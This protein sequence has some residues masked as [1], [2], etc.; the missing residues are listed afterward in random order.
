MRYSI[1]VIA[2]ALVFTAPVHSQPAPSDEGGVLLAKQIL[3]ARQNARLRVSSTSFNGGGIIPER[4]A[5]NGENASPPLAWTKGPQGTRS[6]AILAEDVT[7]SADGAVVHHHWILYDINPS[8]TR[9]DSGMAKEA[10]LG[11]GASQAKNLEGSIGYSGP[12]PQE[13]Q[14]NTY[15]FQ[16]F[17]LNTKLNLDPQT[18]TREMVTEA[19]KGKVLASGDLIGKFADK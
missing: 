18:A 14:N 4:H 17:A 11:N 3:P 13:G 16:V 5:K 2:L 7:P 10:S 15:H 12:N 9:I 8:V 19:M 6:Y 1:P